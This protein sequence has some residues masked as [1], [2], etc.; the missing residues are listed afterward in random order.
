M[1]ARGS[2]VRG[3]IVLDRKSMRRIISSVYAAPMSA[4]MPLFPLEVAV[5]PGLVLP[6][7]VFEPRYRHM[8]HELLAKADPDERLF[9]IVAQRPGRSA[10]SDGLEGMYDI[11]VVMQ[12]REVDELP[13]GRF[14]VICTGLHRFSPAEIST[15]P[16][17]EGADL[18]RVR[19][20]TLPDPQDQEVGQH[21]V[22]GALDAFSHY[23]RVLSGRIGQ[24]AE[25]DQ[26]EVMP[27]DPSVLSFLMT[28]AIALPVNERQQLLACH[29]AEDRLRSVTSILQRESRLIR[30]FSAMPALDLTAGMPGPN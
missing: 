14:D 27:D 22:A 24:E 17:S 10:L 28:A 3:S 8:I 20:R 29:T 30:A 18:L 2:T 23:R 6:L 21:I 7:H 16:M 25:L 5:V 19:I 11:G 4:W 1:T 15:M 13:D 12:L 9:A 26:D